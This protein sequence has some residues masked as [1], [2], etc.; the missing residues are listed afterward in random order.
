MRLN[1]DVLE[2]I[3][4]RARARLYPDDAMPNLMF[5]VLPNGTRNWLLRLNLPMGETH[6]EL[7]GYPRLGLPRR[8]ILN[9]SS[10]SWHKQR[11]RRQYY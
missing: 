8:K 2:K 6:V 4:P 11:Y 7:G 5:Q 9:L 3:V 10:R 1:T